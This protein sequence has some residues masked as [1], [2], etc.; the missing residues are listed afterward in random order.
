MKNS[1]G[2][3]VFGAGAGSCLGMTTSSPLS[4]SPCSGF[5]AVQAISTGWFA[6]AA[7]A[8]SS[9]FLRRSS[10]SRSIWSLARLGL[11]RQGWNYHPATEMWKLPSIQTPTGLTES[12]YPT[13]IGRKTTRNIAMTRRLGVQNTVQT[14]M[15]IYI[16]PYSIQKQLINYIKS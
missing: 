4:S 2:C 8:F 10:S 16:L 7:R 6:A 15:K 13:L 12:R 11:T 3:D 5:P 14:N 1:R 9:S